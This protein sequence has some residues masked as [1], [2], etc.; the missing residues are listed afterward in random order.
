MIELKF[1][2]SRVEEFSW[3][4]SVILLWREHSYVYMSFIEFH[5]VKFGSMFRCFRETRGFRYEVHKEKFSKG[6][7]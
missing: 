7:H 5:F 1:K 2:I 4:L 6:R 3:V